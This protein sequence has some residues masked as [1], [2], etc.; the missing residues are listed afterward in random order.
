MEPAVLSGL[1]APV[2]PFPA[3]GNSETFSRHPSSTACEPGKETMRTERFEKR[4]RSQNSLRDRTGQRQTAAAGR[5]RDRPAAT[6]TGCRNTL[7]QDRRSDE[8]EQFLIV[9]G[10]T[11]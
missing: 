2:R 10:Y 3:A 8:D 1:R 9:C 5:D 4:E 6:D 7:R 11:A